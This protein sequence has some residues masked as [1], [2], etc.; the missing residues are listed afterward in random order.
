MRNWRALNALF[1]TTTMLEGLAF[2]HITAY[3][4]LFLADLG[5]TPSEVSSWTGIHYAVMTGVAFPLAP[6][7]GALA[8]RYSRRLIIVRSQYLEAVA[9]VIMAFAPDV[10]WLLAARVLLGMTFGNVSVVIATQAQL[11]PRKH[12]GTAIATVQAAMPIAAS[13]GPPVGAGLIE[14]VGIRG[15]F[16]IDAGLALTAALLVTFLMR[17]PPKSERKASVLARTGQTL[18]LVWRRPALRW[19]FLCLF[20]SIGSRAVV[21]VYLPVRITELSDNPAPM[22]GLILGVSGVVT[23]VATFASARL[24]DDHGGI[25]WFLPS[26]L[27]GAVATLGVAVLP[28]LWLI[29]ALTWVRALPFAAANTILVAHLTR[30]VPSAEQ[31]VILSLTPLPRNS[32]MFVVPIVAAAVAPFGVALA[33]SVGALSYAVAGLTGWLAER[34]TPG[35]IEEARRQRDVSPPAAPP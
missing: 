8:E 25:R 13:I 9:Y 3:T 24:V 18:A 16:L 35:E 5:L 2:G 21:E 26:M 28:D 33:L 17:E 6:F 22:I 10:W 7:W 1:L 34:E 29:A 20:L 4:P 27:L 11:T 30:V 19:N 23:A 12:L 32:A 15:L 14:L 31:T